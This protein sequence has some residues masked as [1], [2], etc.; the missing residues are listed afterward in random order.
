MSQTS[1]N[2]RRA[3]IVALA[4]LQAVCACRAAWATGHSSNFTVFLLETAR[5]SCYA[6]GD[7]AARLRELAERNNWTAPSVEMLRKFAHPSYTLINGWTFEAH[8][9]AFAVQQ[10]ENASDRSRSCSITTKLVS[11]QEYEEFKAAWDRSFTVDRHDDR[12]TPARLFHFDALTRPPSASLASTLSFDRKAR[13][14]TV[15]ITALPPNSPVRDSSRSGKTP[16][17]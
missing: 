13:T 14:F 1:T 5:S 16:S 15:L 17:S 11:E 10:T 3:A 7:D 4:L 12:T 2:P 8:R 9:R 6:L